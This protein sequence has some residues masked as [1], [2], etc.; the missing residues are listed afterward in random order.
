M[1]DFQYENS[2]RGRCVGVDEVGCGP[3]A[4]PLLSAACYIDQKNF[5]TELAALLNDS[6]ALSPKKRER[7]YAQLLDVES[8][9]FGLGIV[10]IDEFNCIGLK[11]A[12]PLSMKR[13]IEN[14]PIQ[15]D[16]VLIDGVRDP[17]LNVP[18]IMIKKGDSLSCSIAAA[19]IY[20]KVTRDKIM[21]Q[22][23]EIYPQ[24]HFEKNAGYGTREHQRAIE[25]YG[26][27]PH[28]RLCYAPIRRYLMNHI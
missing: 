9:C 13:A 27:T 23:S 1:P 15:P 3:W 22:I 20:A 11:H 28:H 8:I 19:S 16:Y 6:K 10:E 7:I 18:T 5:P 4:G 25:L 2:M 21:Q 17:K 26:I 12:L 14:L 24:Y